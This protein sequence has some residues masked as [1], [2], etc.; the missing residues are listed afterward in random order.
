[1]EKEMKKFRDFESAREFAS[2]L[3]LKSVREWEKICKSGNKPDDIPAIPSR[4]YKNKGWKDWGNFLGT[5]NIYPQDKE[6]R[7]FNEVKKFAQSLGLKSR[8]GWEKYCKSGE[9]PNDVPSSPKNNYKKEW[10]GWGNFLGTGTLRPQDREYRPYKEAREFVQALNLK[11]YGEWEKYCKS[12]NKPD[13][14][15]AAPWNTYKEWKKK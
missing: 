13:D 8:T 10:K 11:N 14:I 12:G 15:P 5:D 1:V 2:K 6:F 7:S 3:G 9:K 4:N